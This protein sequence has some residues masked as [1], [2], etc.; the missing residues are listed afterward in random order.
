MKVHDPSS[1]E[2]Q[3]IHEQAGLLF[4]PQQIGV[5]LQVDDLEEFK[6]RCTDPGDP[7]GRTFQNGRHE[8][9]IQHRKDLKKMAA[10]GNR[11]AI[12]RLAQLN[13]SQNESL[14]SG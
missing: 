11:T 2:L 6:L 12:E 5:Y 7:I 9:E 13:A 1:R 14:V 3:I 4:T 10:D 8:F